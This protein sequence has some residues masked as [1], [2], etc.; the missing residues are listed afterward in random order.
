[1]EKSNDANEREIER[2]DFRTGV[3]SS[4]TPGK[5]TQG[6]HITRRTIA[7]AGSGEDEWSRHIC[8]GGA[9]FVGIWGVSRV[10][11]LELHKVGVIYATDAEQKAASSGT[12]DNVTKQ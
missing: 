6:I 8:P 3:S 9:R 5:L 4:P 7:C 10:Q 1:M 11:H 12:S 2:V